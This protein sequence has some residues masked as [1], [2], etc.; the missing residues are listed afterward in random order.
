MTGGPMLPP[1]QTGRCTGSYP[2][3]TRLF[4]ISSSMSASI[5]SQSLLEELD[6]RQN[7]V[8]EQLEQLNT[9]IE[10]VLKE[11]LLPKDPQMRLVGE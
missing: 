2:C 7:E 3:L 9:R 5:S 1:R 6:A 11:C 8:L 10:R 4:A